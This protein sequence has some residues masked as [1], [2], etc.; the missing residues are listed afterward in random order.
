VHL[1]SCGH[2]FCRACFK[3]YF[4]EKVIE[5]KG[6]IDCLDIDCKKLINVIN[7]RYA[8]TTGEFKRLS[9]ISYEIFLI[10]N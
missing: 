4:K 9:D 3:K 6:K 7:A 2:R 5:G 10:N 8:F 1:E